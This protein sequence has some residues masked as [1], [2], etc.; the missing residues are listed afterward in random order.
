MQDPCRP[1][2][3]Q[4]LRLQ[5]SPNSVKAAAVLN[6]TIGLPELFGSPICVSARPQLT[7]YRGK[8]LSGDPQERGTPVHAASFL[9]K[10]EIVLES[11]LLARKRD[12]RLILVHEIFH[13]VWL[14]L[15]NPKRREFRALLERELK[16]GA[17]GE[18]G[19]SAEVHKLALR[20][21]VT[22]DGARLEYVCESFCDTAAWLY[23][24]IKHSSNWTLASRWQ[25]KR[26]QWFEDVFAGPRGC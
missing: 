14:R 15:G 10:R 3:S 16:A 23:A 19:E 5:L 4:R 13:F 25:R 7:A 21:N 1:C 18:L 11:E 9:R 26:R 2:K 20:Q 6:T 8:L 12:L 22:S 24:G 17:R